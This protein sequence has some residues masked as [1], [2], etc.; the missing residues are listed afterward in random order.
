MTLH[1]RKRLVV[2]LLIGVVL[3][4]NAALVVQWLQRV[5]LIDLARWIRREYVTGT[6]LE[7]IAPPCSAF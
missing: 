4:A 5:A 1:V 6:A 2:C 3:L 7:R